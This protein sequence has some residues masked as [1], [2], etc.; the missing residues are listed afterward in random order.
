LENPIEQS[1]KGEVG[2]TENIGLYDGCIHSVNAAKPRARVV[3]YGTEEEKK[4]VFS[5]TAKFFV[6]K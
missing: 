4:R 5:K 6:G 3:Q 2:A 1:Q